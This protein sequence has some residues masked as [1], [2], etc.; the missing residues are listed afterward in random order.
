MRFAAG[1]DERGEALPLDD[2]LAA[3]LRPLAAAPDP[4]QLVRGLL[5]VPEVFGDDLA[6]DEALVAALVRTVARLRERGTLGAIA[7]DGA[8]S[9]A[10]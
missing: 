6:G 10:P 5:S 9:S 1:V 3:R 7:A 8:L 2:P 4:E